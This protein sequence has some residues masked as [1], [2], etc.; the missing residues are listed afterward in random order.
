[1]AVLSLEVDEETKTRIERLKHL[2]WSELLRPHIMEI[3]NKEEGRLAAERGSL[4][5]KDLAEIERDRSSKFMFQE[6]SRRI[7]HL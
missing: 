4:S 3:V 7:L 1:M 2:N 5:E 6:L